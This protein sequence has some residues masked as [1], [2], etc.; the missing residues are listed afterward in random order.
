[1]KPSEFVRYCGDECLVVFDL[2]LAPRSEWPEEVEDDED[3]SPDIE[4]S[5]CPFCGAH[6]SQ[7]RLLHDRPTQI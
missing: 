3:L 2:C 1:M 4:P 7:L 6:V 5:C